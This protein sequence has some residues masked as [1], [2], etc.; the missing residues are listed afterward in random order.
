MRHVLPISLVVA[1]CAACGDSS[2]APPEGNRVY[3]YPLFVE[4]VKEDLCCPQIGENG[5]SPNDW[6]FDGA[7]SDN[8]GIW[9]AVGSTVVLR[10]HSPLYQNLELSFVVPDTVTPDARSLGYYHPVARIVRLVPA[11][12]GAR[13][14]ADFTEPTVQIEIYA[15]HGLAGV[16]LTSV[17]VYLQACLNS[18]NL[19]ETRITGFASGSP[20]QADSSATDLQGWATLTGPWAGWPSALPPLGYGGPD[21]SRAWQ[22][23]LNVT[24][25]D[26]LG[27]KGHGACGGGFIPSSQLDLTCRVLFL[28]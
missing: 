21:S 6:E 9:A 17:G 14:A 18:S 27:H 3:I 25:E 11:L 1:A 13:W 10:V 2:A 28:Y 7:E 15:P 4:A 26:D 24:I 20:W 12:F 22:A 19:C 23:T 8:N 5:G 16:R